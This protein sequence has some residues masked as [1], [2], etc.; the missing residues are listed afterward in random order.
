MSRPHLTLVLDI[1]LLPAPETLSCNVIND[2]LCT[3]ISKDTF[4]LFL[5]FWAALQLVWVTMLC[6]VQLVQ[7][8]RNQ[9]T[10]ENMR[11]SSIT[12]GGASQAITSALV[13]GTPNP[14]A[15]GLTSAGHGPTPGVA[16]PAAGGGHGHGHGHGHHHARK[17]GFLGQWMGLLGLDTFFATAQGRSTRQKNP[18]SR[19][20]VTNCRDFWLDS[21]PVFRTRKPGSGMLDGEVVDYYKMYEPPLRMSHGG[22]SSSRSGGGNYVS[23]A[24]DEPESAV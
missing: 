2:N 17:G 10:Y 18:F 8:S 20:L 4:T 23:V 5:T 19:G 13:A 9:T 6:C 21:A 11:G 16:P 14:A 24:G 15:A 22:G 3:I 1:E 7:I 12:A